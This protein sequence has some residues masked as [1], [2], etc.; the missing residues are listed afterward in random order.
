MFFYPNHPYLEHLE[1]FSF[2]SANSIVSTLKL[3][4]NLSL[5]HCSKSK[6][7][8]LTTRLLSEELIK[9]EEKLSARASVF[10]LL[11]DTAIFSGMQAFHFFQ[12]VALFDSTRAAL[13][14]CSLLLN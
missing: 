11:L 14:A 12:K 2:C 6:Q 1:F 4:D 9:L 7:N 8:S 13:T 10:K 5:Q 3:I